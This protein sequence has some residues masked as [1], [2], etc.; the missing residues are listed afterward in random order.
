MSSERPTVGTR[1][2]Y[3]HFMAIPTRWM[4]NDVYGHVNNV[5]YYSYFDTLI[6][7]YLID[8]GGLD[9]HA[10]PVIGLAVESLCR[11]YKSFAYPE[12]IDGGLRVGRLGTTSVRYEIG[13]FGGD[14][15]DVQARAEGHFIHVFVDR[16][17]Q[18][19]TPIPAL[20]RAALERLLIKA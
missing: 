4:D 5:V 3:R 18:R 14:A 20:M 8:E 12:T 17:T 19:P 2:D 7:R 1:A 6:N 15:S 16:A 9:F 11:Y 10:G 13:L